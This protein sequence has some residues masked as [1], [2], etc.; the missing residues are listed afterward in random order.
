MSG[1]SGGGRG[2]EVRGTGGVEWHCILWGSIN[3]SPAS[4]SV[5]HKS[6]RVGLGVVPWSF[7]ASPVTMVSDRLHHSPEHRDNRLFLIFP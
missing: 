2:M 7:P 6:P 1:S 3:G 5:S 4:Q